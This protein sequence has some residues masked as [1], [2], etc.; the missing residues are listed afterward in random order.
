V[1]LVQ[2][3]IDHLARDQQDRDMNRTH[4]AYVPIV[5]ITALASWDRE[6]PTAVTKGWW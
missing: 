4:A 6:V 5:P 1:L 3:A 2:G